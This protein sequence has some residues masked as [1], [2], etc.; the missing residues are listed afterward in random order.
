VVPCYNEAVRLKTSEFEEFLLE[1]RKIRFLFVNDGSSDDTAAV[2]KRFRIGREEYVQI[3][4]KV[5]NGGKA[6]AVREGMLAALREG[7]SEYVG[8]WDADLATPLDA[9]PELLRELT[10]NPGIQ[11]VFGSRV[12]LLGREV[13]RKA[14]RHYLGRLFATVVSLMLRLPVYDTQ[15]GAKLF[16]A[17]PQFESI[18]AEEFISRWVFDVEIIARVL[19]ASGFNISAVESQICEFP[20]KKWDDVAGSKVRGSDFLRAL[21]DV[22]R[23]YSKYLS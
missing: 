2:I 23:I 12:R 9:I 11:M 4:D 7:T 3:L 5:Q 22:M 6:E 15:C 14:I 10:R 8:F 20:V 18:L 1:G 16:R 19:R 21:I 13:N 17:T